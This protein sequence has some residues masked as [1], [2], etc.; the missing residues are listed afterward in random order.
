MLGRERDGSTGGEGG[1]VRRWAARTISPGL[2]KAPLGGLRPHAAGRGRC[3][4]RARLLPAAAAEFYAKHPEVALSIVEG[5]Y[6][7]LVDP[8]RDGEIDMMIG[9]VRDPAPGPDLVQVPL[10]RDRPVIVGRR[11]HPLAR[12]IADDGWLDTGDLGLRVHR[13]IEVEYP[14]QPGKSY[15]L[16]GSTNLA[17]WSDIGTALP[18]DGRPVNRMFST[19]NGG[20][21]SFHH[22]RLQV[23]D[24]PTNGLAPWSLAGISVEMDD[25]PGGDVMNFSTATRGLDVSD[26]D[27]DPFTYLYSRLGENEAKAAITYASNRSDV[28]TLAFTGPVVTAPAMHSAM[29]SHPAVRE[30]VERVARGEEI[31]ITKHGHPVAKLVP[32]KLTTTAEGRRKLIDEWRETAKGL[33]LGGHEIEELIAEGRT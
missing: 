9:A 14:T 18:G 31:V 12:L 8:L 33:S 25:E 16:Q 28:V 3:D 23:I 21:V 26:A 32:T 5:S 29:W 11:G 17:D 6:L 7:E 22:Y 13:A 30:N 10:F 19:R 27:S 20:E 2:G 4:C 15:T 24:G 1:S